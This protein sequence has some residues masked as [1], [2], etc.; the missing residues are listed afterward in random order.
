MQLRASEDGDGK[1]IEGLAV[2]FDDVIDTFEGKEVFDRDCSFEGLESA[3]L[4]YQHDQLIGSITSGEVRD[5]GLHITARISDTSLGR[6]ALA[7]LNDGVLDSLSIGFVPLESQRSEDGVSHRRK[8][9]LLETSLVSWPAYENAKISQIR[10]DNHSQETIMDTAIEERFDGV[11]AQIRQLAATTAASSQS[12]V[13][14]GAQY[15]SIGEF[16]TKLK[17]EDED[18]TN[19]YSKLMKREFTGE[20]F[21]DTQTPAAWIEDF[22]NIVQSR[23]SIL[24]LF[25]VGT[26][27]QFGEVV[28]YRVLGTN[29]MQV[30]K[31]DKEGDALAFGKIDLLTKTADIDT[32]GGYT[33][34]SFQSVERADTSTLTTAMEAMAIAYAQRTETAAREHVYSTI[35]A[36]A[37]TDNKLTVAKDL[38]ALSAEDWIDIIIDAADAMDSKGASIGTLGVSSDVFKAIAKLTRNGDALMS[39]SSAGIN[40]LGSIDLQGID[41][42]LQNVRVKKL[43][44]AENSTVAFLDSRALKRWESPGAPFRLQN[45]N[46]INLTDDF[47]VYGYMAFGTPFPDG[48]LPVVQGQ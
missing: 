30:K 38:A 48:I 19:L 1:T 16:I 46:I 29:T 12:T 25:T 45:S 44:G 33:S 8:V 21:A 17:Q 36:Q 6:D 34:L 3:K 40:Q 47:S 39:T 35:D 28:S 37:K 41:G 18:A 26:W 11:E 15:R 4:Y 7:L 13:P 9:R 10:S 43:P 22:I 5:D 24:N 23:R 31:Q 42:I 27:P 14:L 20:V 2:P 32:Y